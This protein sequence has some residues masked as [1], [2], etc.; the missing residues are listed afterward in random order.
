M[1]PGSSTSSAAPPRCGRAGEF[2]LVRPPNPP[3]HKGREQFWAALPITIPSVFETTPGKA[4]LNIHLRTHEGRSLALDQAVQRSLRVWFFGLGAGLPLISARD[5]YEAGQGHM[6]GK[7]AGLFTVFDARGEMLDQA[8]MIRYLNE[9][10]WFPS[11][12]LSEYI[13]W[14]SVDDQSADSV[15]TDGDK[16]IIGRWF[17]DDKGRIINFTAKRYR[18]INGDYSLDN[19]STPITDYGALAGLNLPVAGQAMWHLPEGDLLYAEL[20]VTELEYNTVQAEK[21]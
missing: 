16:S 15:F 12:F 20:E 3:P 4:L 17:F 11:A 19:W 1:V 8:T 14:H 10:M 6:F 13:A 7:V 18:E 5:R 9:I 21:R 2:P